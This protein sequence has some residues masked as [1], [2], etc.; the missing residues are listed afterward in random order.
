ML[1]SSTIRVPGSNL[2]R[3][4]KSKQQRDTDANLAL[5][6]PEKGSAMEEKDTCFAQAFFRKVRER[7]LSSSDCSRSFEAFVQNLYL[8]V[9]KRS[10]ASDDK[11]SDE[12]EAVLGR[13]LE[14]L[15]PHRDLVEEFPVFLN[16]Q[17]A[18]RYGCFGSYLSAVQMR[19]FMH[20]LEVYF[21]KQPSHVN[22][23]VSLLSD[24]NTKPNV[25]YENIKDEIL[26]LLKGNTIL[27]NHFLRL[28]PHERPP[29]SLMTDFEEL[30]FWEDAD[31][32]AEEEPVETVRLPEREP[33][34]RLGGESCFVN[35]K[36]VLQ[37]AKGIRPARVSF[38]SPAD[39]QRLI[40]KDTVVPPTRPGKGRARKKGKANEGKEDATS[41]PP[42]VRALQGV[43]PEE[44]LGSLKLPELT[45]SPRSQPRSSGK[46]TR[47][48]TSKGKD[49][50]LNPA[51]QKA[52]VNENA[53]LVER[54]AA[55]PKL[56][57]GG[58][59]VPSVTECERPFANIGKEVCSSDQET[60]TS[61]ENMEV[62]QCST[63][64]VEESMI[65]NDQSNCGSENGS[66][67]PVE[68]PWTREE[69]RI[70]LQTF[71][72]EGGK[73]DTLVKIKQKLPE[74]SVTEIASRFHKL[75][76]LFR[77]MSGPNTASSET[78]DIDLEKDKSCQK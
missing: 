7:L 59:G 68:I 62:Q 33:E 72:M 39:F 46:G 67:D 58:D 71:Q 5:L 23:I 21:T 77:K 51:C 9:D 4:R 37:T 42:K 22:K 15:A 65:K 34:D 31:Q 66:S 55:S 35:G 27:I 17:Q 24:L 73:S 26:P 11:D 45:A 40:V 50:R 1:A 28:L 44:D 75:M 57:N 8:L 41:P 43:E 38:S 29:D 48:P 61:Q 64:T 54:T 10:S 63:I 53:N 19:D 6:S 18:L 36:V 52:I 47:T 76:S 25:T 56:D 16:S 14:I 32:V 69:D 74:R 3:K 60:A 78:E 70:I 12:V 13:L 30:E 20:K 2:E 49:S